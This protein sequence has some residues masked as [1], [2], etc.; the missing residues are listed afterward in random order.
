[1]V[2]WSF[3]NARRGAQHAK[4]ITEKK[5]IHIS[6]FLYIKCFLY[7]QELEIYFYSIHP[8]WTHYHNPKKNLDNFFT[9]RFTLKILTPSSTALTEPGTCRI[10]GVARAQQQW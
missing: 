6:V 4:R 1:M 3:R 8:S 2:F 10:S 9:A 7:K 5:D